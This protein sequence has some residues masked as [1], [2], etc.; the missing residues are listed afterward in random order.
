MRTDYFGIMS[1]QAECSLKAAELLETI[2]KDYQ[3]SKVAAWREDMHHIEHSADEVRHDALKRLAREFITPI[4]RDDLLRLI[5]ILDDVTDAIDEVVIELYMFNV[6]RLPL[7]VC[8]RWTRRCKSFRN[9]RNPK[10]SRP[11]WLR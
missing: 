8:G 6:A 11:C 1:R 10:S 5:Q 4:E 7:K 3:P 9:T 2:L